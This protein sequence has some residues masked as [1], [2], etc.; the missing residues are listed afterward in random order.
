MSKRAT[1]TSDE[2]MQREVARAYADIYADQQYRRMRAQ[3]GGLS[4][5]AKHGMQELS[6]AG[7]QGQWRRYVQQ[8][9]PDGEV[10][11][12]YG[13]AEVNQR[14]EAAR[15]ANMR[16]IALARHQKAQARKGHD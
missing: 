14:A 13:Q 12:R 15:S 5:K 9:D 7:V 2:Q 3:L 11:R 8:V 1:G 16:R 4:Y 10:L 6:L